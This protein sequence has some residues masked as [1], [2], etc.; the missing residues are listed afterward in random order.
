MTLPGKL[1]KHNSHSM[2]WHAIFLAF[3]WNFIDIDTVIPAM[4][5]AAG[6]K[7]IHTSLFFIYKIDCRK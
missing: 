6:G 3:A 5:V 4:L 1:S 2:L 7:A